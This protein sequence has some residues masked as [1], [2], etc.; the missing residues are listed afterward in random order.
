M[1]LE[2]VILFYILL[3]CG[4]FLFPTSYVFKCSMVL[5]HVILFYI[6][7]V[8]GSFYFPPVMSLNVQWSWNMGGGGRVKKLCTL[9]MYTECK[10]GLHTFKFRCFTKVEPIFRIIQSQSLIIYWNVLTVLNKLRRNG[11]LL[12]MTQLPISM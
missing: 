2:Y 5:E 11:T 7:L 6:L 12:I 3:V 9:Y 8:C 10:K 4:S 1:V